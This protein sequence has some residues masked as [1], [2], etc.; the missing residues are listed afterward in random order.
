MAEIGPPDP[1]RFEEVVLERIK[2]LARGELSPQLAHDLEA[3]VFQDA[4]G[5]MADR[6]VMQLR[7]H[8][9]ANHVGTDTQRVPWNRTIRFVE[10]RTK[11]V[12]PPRVV[13][14]P[15]FATGA[16]L[17]G[18]AAAL[19]SIWLLLACVVHTVALIAAWHKLAPV[20]VKVE[21]KVDREIVGEA[22]IDLRV[23]DTFPENTRV[24]PRDM[25]T[26]YRIAMPELRD[27]NYRTEGE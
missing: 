23:L 8:V 9:Y 4:L 3:S 16:L 5:F 27:V 12:A 2:V 6:L 10:T 17:A 11:R 1:I 21:V 7:T 25:G 13:L 26:A 20:D 14:L 19:L 15:M 24:F 22:V 18:L